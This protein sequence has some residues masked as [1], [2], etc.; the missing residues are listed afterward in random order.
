METRLVKAKLI[1]A[2]GSEQPLSIVTHLLK[3]SA[4]SGLDTP[5]DGEN[6]TATI[7]GASSNYTI[8]ESVP[9]AV[10][11]APD[12][13]VTANEKTVLGTN[14]VALEFAPEQRISYSV[15]KDVSLDDLTN[16]Q[17]VLLK[18]PTQADLEAATGNS[19][20]SFAPTVDWKLSLLLTALLV[21]AVVIL[22]RASLIRRLKYM[23]YAESGKKGLHEV[24]TL[25]NDGL[26]HLDGCDLD[27][28]MMRYKEAKLS[29][30]RLSEYGQNE[31][32]DDLER[33]RDGL[34]NAYFSQLCDRIQEAMT[35]GRLADAIDDFER[36]EATFERLGEEEQAGL[37]VIVMEIGRR[38]GM[39]DDG[40]GTESR[41]ATGGVR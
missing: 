29:Y 1:M 9:Q 15:R 32:Y 7:N 37:I 27:G 36:L 10:A 41:S 19:I 21:I 22:R 4:A 39:V 14:P 13:I 18:K 6:V 30:E 24:R 5:A 34:D 8:Y 2:D 38:L 17:T 3:Y 35:D 25:I 16:V 20:L 12:D 33:L 23:V 26:T 31:A 40:S 28:A 11:V